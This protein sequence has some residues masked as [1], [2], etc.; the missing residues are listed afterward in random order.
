MP[1]PEVY[2]PLVTYLQVTE[3]LWCCA[4]TVQN[5]QTT[6]RRR[7]RTFLTVRSM[8]GES[9]ISVMLVIIPYYYQGCLY[10][11]YITLHSFMTSHWCTELCRQVCVQDYCEELE[12][13]GLDDLH[14]Q[15][16]CQHSYYRAKWHLPKPPSKALT[17][18]TGHRRKFNIRPHRMRALTTLVPGSVR[19]TNDIF[20]IFSRI[21]ITLRQP[22]SWLSSPACLSS[23]RLFVWSSPPFL[24]STHLRR[25]I[26]LRWPRLSS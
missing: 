26:S 1:S 9:F 11:I 7:G 5:W 6:S 3:E 20:G 18:L 24:L 16:C 10:Y 4:G 25:N 12:Y 23:S 19:A 14:L 2:L 21:R 15:P 17:A 13:W 22:R 8:S